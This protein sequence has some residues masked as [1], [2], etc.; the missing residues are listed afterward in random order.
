MLQF[1]EAGIKDIPLI[2]EIAFAVWP[3][4]YAAILT[5]EQTDYM[6]QMMYSPSSL[7]HQIVVQH[8]RFILA[9][10]NN[11]A[12]GFASWSFIPESNIY[13]LHKIYVLPSCQGSGVGK[14][15][16]EQVIAAI[17][18][19]VPAILELNV[20]RNNTARDFYIHLG[21]RIAREE[22]IA[23]GNGFFMNDYVMQKTIGDP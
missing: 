13:R 9:C 5:A 1:K 20:N 23:I 11:E 14:K 3:K 15:L 8:H 7:Q 18:P 10:N 19:A 2:R 4:A 6:L 16:I 21:F 17:R 12:V 22:D